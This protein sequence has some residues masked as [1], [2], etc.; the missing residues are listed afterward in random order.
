MRQITFGDHQKTPA[1]HC[2]ELMEEERQS[3]LVKMLDYII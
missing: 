3:Q 2:S 1:V